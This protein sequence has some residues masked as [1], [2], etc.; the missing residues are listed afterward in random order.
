ML[1]GVWIV[2]KISLCTSAA[3]SSP[4]M[5]LLTGDGRANSYVSLTL[6]AQTATSAPPADVSLS[7]SFE[8]HK[9]ALGA[10]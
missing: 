10:Q 1:L 6:V 5:S 7:A 8:L 3:V 4:V 2:L 9:F